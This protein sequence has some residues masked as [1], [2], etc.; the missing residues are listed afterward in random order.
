MLN[1]GDLTFGSVAQGET[2]WGSNYK[3]KL[4]DVKLYNVALSASE[5]ST[6]AASYGFGE[7]SSI[8]KQALGNIQIAPNPVS[9][10]LI[11]SNAA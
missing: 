8:N 7:P 5:V 9:E 10:Q 3:G 4:D 6:L 1:D 2:V 11:I